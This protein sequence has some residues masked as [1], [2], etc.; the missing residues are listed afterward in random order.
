MWCH[1]RNDQVATDMRLWLVGHLDAF[2]S[3]IFDFVRVCCDRAEQEVD[4]L[5]PGYTH[6][7]RA[8]P[9]RWSHWIL[10]HAW[11]LMRDAERAGVGSRG[12]ERVMYG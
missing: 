12:E 1:S 5:L 11:A 4:V 7:Q 10:S 9:I 2:R 3:R 8:Q 6:L